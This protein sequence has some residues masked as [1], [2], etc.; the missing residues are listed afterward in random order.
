Q[1]I[2]HVALQVARRDKP[3]A[4]NLMCSVDLVSAGR[5]CHDLFMW[6]SHGDT[7]P[8]EIIS[9]DQWR[10]LLVNLESIQ[11]LDDH[12]IREFLKNALQV[13]PH[14]VIELLKKRLERAASSDDWSFSPLT[15]SFHRDE[16]LG[17]LKVAGSAK[18]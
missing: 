14:L 18:Y 12:W 8:R 10:R 6:L 1:H 3:L 2:G 13:V 11:E 7:I 15:K 5:S 4:V 16:S 9:D 17:V